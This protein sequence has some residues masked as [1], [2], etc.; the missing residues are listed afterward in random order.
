MLRKI[1]NAARNKYA[2]KWRADHRAAIRAYDRAHYD[3]AKKKKSREQ[4]IR[5]ACCGPPACT[6]THINSHRTGRGRCRDCGLLHVRVPVSASGL[7]D[8]KPAFA[9]T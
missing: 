9:E 8:W 1:D 6:H 3:A 5:A 4:A 7:W 2:A